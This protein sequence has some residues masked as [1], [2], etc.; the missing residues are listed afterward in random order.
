M[1]AFRDL[2]DATLN[3]IIAFLG[4]PGRSE[5]AGKRTSSGPVVASGGAPGGLDIPARTGPQYSQ[6]GGPPYPAGVD[7]PQV[8]YYTRWG[9]YP[10]QPYVISPPWSSIVAY[11]LNTGTIK[12]KV[13]FG[14]DAVATEAHLVNATSNRQRH[15]G[16]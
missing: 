14:Q 9:L 5:T 3:A 12:W 11:D 7:A 6:L 10:D 8:R 2:D 4:A 13:P 15:K 16:E 1:P